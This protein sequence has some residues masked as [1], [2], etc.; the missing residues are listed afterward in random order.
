MSAGM[1]SKS[2]VLRTRD[3]SEDAF[4]LRQ[5]AAEPDRITAINGHDPVDE[6]EGH[7]VL[8]QLRYEVRR[9][10]L[11]QVRA[12]AGVAVDGRTVWMTLLWY[13]TGEHRGVVGLADD[14]FRVGTL[15]LQ[16]SSH[17]FQ[18]APGSEPRDPVVEALAVEVL[19][20]FGGCRS[21]V[22]IGVGFV[23]ELSAEKP[24]VS[25]GKLDRF[26]Q[27]AD[28]SLRCRCQHDLGPQEAHDLASLDTEILGH[29]D[30]EVI[31]LCRTDHR[32]ADSRVAAGGLDDGLARLELAAALG[33]LDDAQRQP[34]LDRTQRVER[35]DLHV[36][37][38][39]GRRHVVDSHD[40]RTPDRLDDAFEFH[41]SDPPRA[42]RRP[43]PGIPVFRI[44]NTLSIPASHPRRPRG[45]STTEY[46][47]YSEERQRC[48]RR[49]R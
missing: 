17:A 37:I 4:L 8:G 49:L 32:Q 42:F 31:A 16:Q 2:V 45:A 24:T 6:L 43:N 36:E 11:N 22:H 19:E 38:D 46:R 33:I 48:R 21:G 13:S 30:D 9:P 28:A 47:E 27:H 1:S 3:S 39:A 20:N 18:R 25:L 40:R 14:D 10:T 7:G 34:V 23:L 29:D 35:L 26:R 5:L 41:S 44:R 12:E 15:F